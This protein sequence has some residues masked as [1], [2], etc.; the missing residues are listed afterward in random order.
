MS[1]Y[2]QHSGE[3]RSRALA[4]IYEKY[5]DFIESVIR[6]VARNHADREDIYQEVFV[7][8]SQKENFDEIQNI[9]SY[10][11]RLVV[12]KAKEFLRRK[13]TGELKFKEYLELQSRQQ[14][15][16][17][18][19][20]HD[21]LVQDEMDKVVELIEEFLS[22]KESEAVLLRFKYHCD[23]DKAAR[24]MNVKKETLIRYVSTGLKKIRDII[25]GQ[26][27]PEE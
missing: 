7:V 14:V 15:E 8:L 26:E 24:K 9:K 1:Q 3:D 2:K 10:L 12:N 21:M 17:S 6:F 11:Y 23:D 25:K 18:D 5:D 16:E 20:M 27:R 4:E 19:L 13:I 22:K